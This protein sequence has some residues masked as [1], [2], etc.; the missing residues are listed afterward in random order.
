M[1]AIVLALLVATGEVPATRTVEPDVVT[2][3]RGMVVSVSAPAS[4]AGA[5]ILAQGGNAVDGAVATALALAVTYPPAGNLGGGGFMM[6]LPRPGAAPVC[7]EYR[8]TA[9][10]A[11]TANM[12]AMDESHL[13]AKA[14]GVPGTVRG[15][16][17]AH[18]QFGRLPW[19]A[20]VEPAIELAAQGF[21]IDAALAKS[22]N[23]ILAE[24]ASR[25]CGE[26]LRVYAPPPGHAWQA[27][28]RLVQPDLAATLKHLAAHGAEGFYHGPAAAA[29]VAE[30]EAGHGLIT[31]ADLADYAAKVRT[32]M[33]GTYRGY[34]VYAPPP[35][36][37]GGI[38]LIEMLNMLEPLDLRRLGP[39]SPET[40]HLMI[41]AMRRGFLDRA[42]YL[43]DQDF[44]EVP[45]F[46]VGKPYAASLSRQ[47]DR[48]HASS[49]TQLAPDIPLHIEGEHTTHFSVVDSDGMAV[50]NTYTLE[51]SYGSRVM[52][53]GS[54]FLLNNEMGDFNWTAGH[55]DQ[56][57]NIG[58]QPNLIAPGKRMLSSQTPT[59]VLKEGR[60]YLVTGS[61]GGRTIIN[62][63]LCVVLNVLE[64]DMDLPAA[65]AAPRWHHQ[66]LPD[67]VKFEGIQHG[68][69]RVLRA[70]LAA[71]G[72]AF[73]PAAGRQGDAHSI[74]IDSHTGIITGV[75]DRRIS[76][77]AVGVA[78]SASAP[79]GSGRMRATGQ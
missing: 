70:V 72:H 31:A 24:R 51:Q 41:E 29:I 32:P 62:T 7:V 10:A 63:V 16:T 43:G 17:L 67:Q 74:L 1:H 55:T 38:A 79:S 22:L 78:S 28:D 5:A 15:L 14:A 61:P 21:A 9:P 37:A 60:A 34:D 68:D 3:E 19:P 69:Y 50:A 12:F 39:Q 57:G 6:V 4:E 66:W 56:R 52:V 73:D 40:C 44:V 25:G 58:T 45:A 35:P 23:A 47:I 71:M 76:G 48:Q 27:G 8:E 30:M 49:S 26:M 53:R 20:L 75:A 13:G 42:R 11:A 18:A 77:K 64:F 59:L 36:S 33:H 65:V 54:G 46:L 2:A